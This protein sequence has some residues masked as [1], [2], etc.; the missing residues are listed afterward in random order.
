MEVLCAFF[1][2]ESCAEEIVPERLSDS[3][4]VKSKRKSPRL[5][6]KCCSQSIQ[7][8]HL[9]IA[10]CPRQLAQGMWDGVR[11][12]DRQ[13]LLRDTITFTDLTEK[14]CLAINLA[15]GYPIHYRKEL[16]ESQLCIESGC[17]SHY[18]L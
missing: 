7:L 5:G 15:M 9:R 13:P 1:F 2:L 4:E 14:N 8:Q 3:H 17:Y 16:S 18:L 11:I 6:L 10:K 12:R